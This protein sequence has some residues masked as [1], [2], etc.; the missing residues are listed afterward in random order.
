[1]DT[2]LSIIAETGAH[3]RNSNAS[4]LLA[5]QTRA[6]SSLLLALHYLHSDTLYKIIQAINIRFLGTVQECC[7]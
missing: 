5:D 1:M 2:A 6:P 7:S 3:V 4:L